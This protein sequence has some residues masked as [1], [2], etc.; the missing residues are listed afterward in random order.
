MK[1]LTVLGARP[2]FIK[3]AMVSHAIDTYNK[4][5]ETVIVE[6]IVHTG[7]HF[8]SNMSEVFFEQM[9]IPKPDYNLTIS[10]LSHGA[11]TGRMLEKIEEVL[12]IEKPDCLLVYGDTNS[13]L[14]G[15]LAASKYHIPVVHVEAGLRSYN[16]LMP[17]EVNRILTDRVSSLLLCPTDQAV[18]NLKAESFPFNKGSQFQQSIINTGDVMYDAVIYYSKRAINE[19]KLSSLGV[20]EHGYGL[21]TLHR[22]ENTEDPSKLK[23]ILS[24][25]QEIAKN[26]YPI[27]LPLHPRTRNKIKDLDGNGWL[28]GLTIIDPVGYLEMQ[29]LQ[30]D[31]KIIL[32]DSG[33]VQ[34]EAFFHQVPCITLRDETEWVETVDLGWN[35]LAGAN[36]E[37]ILSYAREDNVFASE[38]AYPYGKG[39]AAQKIIESLVTM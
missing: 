9:N 35:K 33:G 37:K 7:Q 14:A 39:N 20:K 16:M 31:A 1:I 3:A 21:C 18:I 5:H 4:A 34:K 25:L 28:D 24:S 15:A 27:V 32:T 10:G 8:D 6:K 17:E 12:D 26:D 22:Q 23:N 11:M 2:Q 38:V 29:R 36:K 13:T 30:M 19:V